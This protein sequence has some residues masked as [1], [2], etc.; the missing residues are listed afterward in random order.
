MIVVIDG[1]A[2]S[3]KSSTAR[4]VAERTGFTFLDSGAFYRAI[5]LLY[6]RNHKN[7]ELFFDQMK[8]C[9]LQV[10]FNDGRFSIRLN[11]E[12]VTELIRDKEVSANVSTVAA[13]PQAREFVNTHLREFVKD[14]S[15]IADGRD[16]G[17]AVFPDAD[18]KFFFDASVEKRAERR[19][20]EMLLNGQQTDLEA[21]KLNIRERDHIDSTRKVAPLRKADDA[22]VV[23]TGLLTLEEQ[24][25]FV[26]NTVK[27]R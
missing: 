4:A 6:L 15:F 19:L 3:G 10:E 11:G 9:D 7:Q 21:V 18:L 16:L 17:T 12:T 23:D 13:M 8:S 22:I 25:Q 26:I 20:N 24:I 14:G 27:G 1:P 2:G 5:T